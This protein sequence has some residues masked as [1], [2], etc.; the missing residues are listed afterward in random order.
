MQFSTLFSTAMAADLI[1]GQ[2]RTIL[3]QI[4]DFPIGNQPQLDERLEPVANA[5]HKAIPL[6]QQGH[7]RLRYYFI[8][9]PEYMQ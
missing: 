2:R 4:T 7:G 5:Q 8:Q 9:I 3:I 6:M 1:M